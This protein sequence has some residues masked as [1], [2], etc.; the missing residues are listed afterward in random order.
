ML[1]LIRFALQQLIGAITNWSTA[2]R[3]FNLRED[4]LSHAVG[5]VHH[6]RLR[7]ALFVSKMRSLRCWHDWT[8]R[9]SCH[10]LL[11][12]LNATFLHCYL[13]SLPPVLTTALA[14]SLALATALAH[15]CQVLTQ[16][17]SQVCSRTRTRRFT[18]VARR[19][20]ENQLQ[21]RIV[22]SID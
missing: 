16:S 4:E 7:A 12:A 9:L 10:R 5:A 20:E 14:H 19:A 1:D 21:Q 11:P 22:S 18:L 13:V 17:M 3:F 15:C 2:T 8:V 6:S